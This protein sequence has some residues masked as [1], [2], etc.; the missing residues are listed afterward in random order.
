MKIIIRNVLK[1]KWKRIYYKGKKTNYDVSN[2]GE[3]RNHKTKKKLKKG[4]KEDG[5][6]CVSLHIDDKQKTFTVHRL[7]A[8]AFIDNPENKKT[9]NHKDG[10]K[11]NNCAYNLE[12]M[13]DEENKK[14]SSINGL[15]KHDRNKCNLKHIPINIVENICLLLQ[16]GTDKKI[17]R[18]KLYNYLEENNLIDQ[19]TTKKDVKEFIHDLYNNNIHK[20]IVKK[21][22]FGNR[23]ELYSRTYTISQIEKVCK[24][25]EEN[26]LDYD[27]IYNKTGV[28]KAMISYIRNKKCWISVSCNYDIDNYN[29]SIGKLTTDKVNKICKLLEINK[30][31]EYISNTLNISKKHIIDIYEGK[32]YKNISK[33]YN[34]PYCTS[35]NK[36]TYKDN[37]EYI[38]RIKKVCKLLEKNK[39]SNKEIS[40]M[41]GIGKATVSDIKT[42][43]RWKDISKNYNINYCKVIKLKDETVNEICKLIEEGD[44]NMLQISNK[45]NISVNIIYSI[46]KRKSYKKISKNYNW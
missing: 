46:K 2:K 27:E 23:D 26:K 22:D 29:L 35:D 14:H 7:V 28:S 43:K 13:T 15:N 16:N 21:Y 6:Y 12:W 24:C 5:Y 1:E 42:G 31:P 37:M 44:M 10:Y 34:I 4:L 11:K 40:K 39:Y 41:T 33:K 38:K 25:L 9:V 32:K 20:D 36:I 45:L 8:L 30:T 19:N 3:V 18:K 17:I